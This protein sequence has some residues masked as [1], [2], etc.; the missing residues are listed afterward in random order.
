MPGPSGVEKNELYAGYLGARNDWGTSRFSYNTVGAALSYTR[1]MN[2][3]WGLFGFAEAS[4]NGDWNEHYYAGRAGARYLFLPEHRI[5]PFI[6][7]SVGEAHLRGITATTTPVGKQ[8]LSHTWNGF[9]AGGS[10]GVLI[11][12]SEHFGVRAEYGD[13]RVPFGIHK[14]DRDYWQEMSAGFTIHF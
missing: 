1:T 8:F 4:T 10:G 9:T 12:L 14:Y 3:H 7:A 2:R 13:Y 6:T 5:H 11:R